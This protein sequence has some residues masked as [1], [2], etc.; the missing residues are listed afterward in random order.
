MHVC[1][2]ANMYALVTVECANLRTYTTKDQFKGRH[3]EV[4]QGECQNIK[5][6]TTTVSREPTTLYD[7]L[8]LYASNVRRNHVGLRP[9]SVSPFSLPL[10][11]STSFTP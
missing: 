8:K 3:T 5:R 10:S 4:Y 6:I 11:S 1:V 9:R 2:Y 7:P